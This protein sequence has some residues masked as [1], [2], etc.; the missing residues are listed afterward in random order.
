MNLARFFSGL[1]P[2]LLLAYIAP[3]IFLSDLARRA[4]NA[5]SDS[6]LRLRPAPKTPDSVTVVRIDPRSYRRMGLPP[7][8]SLSFEQIADAIQRIASADPKLIVL[9][10]FFA[11]LSADENANERLSQALASAPTAIARSV[12][13]YIDTDRNGKRHLDLL[14]TVPAPL[15]AQN[16]R[17][18]VPMMLRPDNDG[19]V[20][21][22]NLTGLDD[23][24][25]L[26]RTP[27]LAPLLSQVS[28]IISQPGDS[29]LINYYGPPYSLPDIP[30]YKLLQTPQ[31]VSD[32]WFRD[33]V[34]F[35]GVV[36]TRKDNP[37]GRDDAFQTPMS[38]TPMYGVEIHATIA[39][40]LIDGSWI[41]TMPP[42]LTTLIQTLLFSGLFLVIKDASLKLAIRLYVVAAAVW[43]SAS[44]VAFVALSVFVPG[45][46]LFVALLPGLLIASS[47]LELSRRTFF[48]TTNIQVPKGNPMT[49]TSSTE[50]PS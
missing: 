6:W 9:D 12:V 31:E 11:K 14:R 19:V 13:T 42:S 32:E 49:N 26:D 22:I 43:L 27:F 3:S 40:N 50:L 37:V 41:K 24:S 21:R 45:A 48:R 16:A 34:V 47:V 10:I 46:F 29:D 8:E 30:V 20:R 25:P 15:F 35:L 23:S 36:D 7:N 5:L 1:L 39:Q 38:A 4:D 17:M 2:C 28:P 44:Y 33:R 18:V